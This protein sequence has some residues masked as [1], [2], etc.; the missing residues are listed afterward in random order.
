MQ[1]STYNSSSHPCHQDSLGT[2]H[3]WLYA[4][5]IVYWM[6]IPKDLSLYSLET[7][8]KVICNRHRYQNND[9]FDQTN[10]EKL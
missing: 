8:E 9:E 6:D 1:V 3:R 10:V 5:N 7:E 4:S 2:H